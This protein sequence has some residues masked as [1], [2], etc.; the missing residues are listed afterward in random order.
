ML[1]KIKRKA[2][3]TAYMLKLRKELQQIDLELLYITRQEVLK[4]INRRNKKHD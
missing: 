4:E 1:G 2:K 3:Q